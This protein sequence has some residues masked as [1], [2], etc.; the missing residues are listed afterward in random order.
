MA[1]DAETERSV[2]AALLSDKRLQE[3]ALEVTARAGVVYLRGR[4]H[5]ALERR[6]ARQSA[7]SAFGVRAVVNE[8]TIR[9][10]GGRSDPDVEADVRGALACD[11][12]LAHAFVDVSVRDGIVHLAGRLTSYLAKWHAEEAA[13]EVPGA[14]EVVSS[15][16]VVPLPPLTDTAI[17]SAILAVLAWH[18]RVELDRISV[19]VVG[20]VVY[21]RGAVSSRAQRWLVGELASSVVGV[22]EVINELAVA[23]RK[24]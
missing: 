10:T 21:L 18:P 5:S 15:I 13:R 24:G 7:E 9:A 3:A 20:G 19:D 11:P 14:V 4:V 16:A 22:R 6:L 1:Q 2:M 8:L 17:G 12:L 23:R